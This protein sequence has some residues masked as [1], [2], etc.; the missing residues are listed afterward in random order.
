MAVTWCESARSYLGRSQESVM[1]M[2]LEIT[3]YMN[4]RN[5]VKLTSALLPAAGVLPATA[6]GLLHHTPT[7]PHLQDQPADYTIHINTSLVEVGKQ[8]ILSTTTYNGQF[9]GPLLRFKE[10][11]QAIVDIFNDTDTPEQFH[12]HGQF[13]PVGSDRQESSHFQLVTGTN[14]DLRQAV[15]E[16]TFR[17]DLLARINLWSFTLPGLKDRP[18]DLSPNLDY[19]LERWSSQTGSRVTIN[20]E[21]RARFLDFARSPRGIHRTIRPCA[22]RSRCYNTH[23]CRRRRDESRRRDLCSVTGQASR[24]N[25]AL[26]C[27]DTVTDG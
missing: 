27:G 1:E 14:R 9:P 6:S 25:C 20:K 7:A 10:G 5:F 16:G 19:E 26:T 22:G 15:A 3:T 23:I 4:R 18:E 2:N 21:A 17:E 11:Q 8:R 24:L 13:L 12:W